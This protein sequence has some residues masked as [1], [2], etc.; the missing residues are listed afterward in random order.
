MNVFDKLHIDMYSY[1]FNNAD[2]KGMDL[3]ASWFEDS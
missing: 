2:S 1:Q 3:L